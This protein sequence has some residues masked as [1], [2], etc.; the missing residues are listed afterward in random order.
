MVHNE[1][2]EKILEKYSILEYAYQNDAFKK[3]GSTKLLLKEFIRRM[4]LWSEKFAEV[5]KKISSFYFFDVMKA[6]ND[7]SIDSEKIRYEFSQKGIT[8]GGVDLI[9]ISW[10]LNFEGNKNILDKEFQLLPHPYEPVIKIFERGGGG[11]S[12]AVGRIEAYPFI[13]ISLGPKEK[14]LNIES[15]VDIENEEVLNE[16]DRL[17]DADP[18]NL[19]FK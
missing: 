8:I 10:W 16:F 6:Y 9:I 2:L 19:I 13:G 14:F 12:M 3:I 4:R 18:R 7:I 5:G 11:L 1:K 15:F 17:Y